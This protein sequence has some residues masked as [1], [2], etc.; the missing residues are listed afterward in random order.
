MVVPGGGVGGTGA[1]TRHWQKGEWEG[2]GGAGPQ[3][4]LP[5]AAPRLG[6]LFRSPLR[7]DSRSASDSGVSPLAFSPAGT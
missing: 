6:L 3:R 5:V 4:P 7:W 2:E 1:G